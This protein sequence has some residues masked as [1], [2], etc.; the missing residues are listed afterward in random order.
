MLPQVYLFPFAGKIS[1]RF[2]YPRLQQV[3][4]GNVAAAPQVNVSRIS[5][6]LTTLWTLLY[7]SQLD[8]ETLVI[9]F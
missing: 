1:H 5:E 3:S 8:L 4:L 6:C 2:V 9:V 7:R